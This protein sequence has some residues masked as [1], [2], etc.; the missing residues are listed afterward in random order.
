M[1]HIEKIV[2]TY[3]II[4]KT[5]GGFS[6]SPTYT[7]PNTS[8]A[9]NQIAYHYNTLPEAL[10]ASDTYHSEVDALHQG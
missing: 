7:I 10:D 4:T 3:T 2:T 9:S 6:V 5:K 8:L 1:N